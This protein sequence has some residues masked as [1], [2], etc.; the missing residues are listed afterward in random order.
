MSLLIQLPLSSCFARGKEHQLQA[1]SSLP[2]A[3][4]GH[5]REQETP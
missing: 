1:V 3:Y 4:C 5:P 2:T